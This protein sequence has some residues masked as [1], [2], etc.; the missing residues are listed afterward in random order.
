MY[1]IVKAWQFEQ[2]PWRVLCMFA[3]AVH[4]SRFHNAIVMNH[5]VSK[6][7]TRA[8][9]EPWFGAYLDVSPWERL[10]CIQ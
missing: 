10:V 4:R 6:P 2:Q 5:L 1:S 9:K 7:K 8:H 3:I